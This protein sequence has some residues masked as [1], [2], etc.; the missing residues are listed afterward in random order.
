MTIE[1]ERRGIES[2]YERRIPKGGNSGL[3]F[4][5]IFEK[6]GYGNEELQEL[7]VFIDNVKNAVYRIY[8]DINRNLGQPE[9]R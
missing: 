3:R 7:R 2:I 9:Q 5:K 4:D 8:Q 1:R 6:R